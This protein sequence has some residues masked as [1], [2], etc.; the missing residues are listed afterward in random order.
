VP[1]IDQL[2]PSRSEI[3]TAIAASLRQM[4]ETATDIEMVVNRTDIS[5]QE[6]IREFGSMHGLILALATELIDALSLPLR[7]PPQGK[8]EI[9]Q[10]LLQFGQGCSEAYTSSYLR[11]LYRIAITE[12]I[13]HS[14]LGPKFYE[15]GPHRLMQR[16]ASF[17]DGA[18][19]AGA[20]KPVDSHLAAD[21]FLS[22]VRSDLDLI[23]RSSHSSPAKE[24]DPRR[25]AEQAMSLFQGGIL[26]GKG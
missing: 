15:V 11:G 24:T 20:I 5:E 8:E 25:V 18:Q 7:D 2:T 26:G 1:E 22:L 3:T 21:H 19:Q 10:R 16:L 13:R 23:D 14:G 9:V 17:L 12:S 4:A 6:L